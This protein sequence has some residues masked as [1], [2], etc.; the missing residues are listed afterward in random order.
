[1]REESLPPPSSDGQVARNQRAAARVDICDR[2][3]RCSAGAS[4]E[5]SWTP[6][7]LESVVYAI[8][9]LA[10]TVDALG[11]KLSDFMCQQP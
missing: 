3:S 4:V 2:A 5:S 8:C 1:M 9:N 6:E 7:Q 10:E 11:D